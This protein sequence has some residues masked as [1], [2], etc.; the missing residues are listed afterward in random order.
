MACQT[1]TRSIFNAY[2]AYI[3]EKINKREGKRCGMFQKAEMSVIENT[4]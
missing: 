4:H 2:K 1:T 3:K